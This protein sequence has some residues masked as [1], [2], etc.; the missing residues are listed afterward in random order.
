MVVGDFDFWRWLSVCMGGMESD[1]S[2]FTRDFWSY[3]RG[4]NFSELKKKKFEGEEFRHIL[5]QQRHW[6]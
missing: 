6:L 3:G 4:I 1:V 2:G 5:F